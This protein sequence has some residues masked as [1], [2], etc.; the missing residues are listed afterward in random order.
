MQRV[1]KDT[2]SNASYTDK[3]QDDIPANQ[4]YANQSLHIEAKLLFINLLK[5]FLVN[6]NTVERL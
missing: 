4:S 3:Y 1:N 6:M 2:N 5:L